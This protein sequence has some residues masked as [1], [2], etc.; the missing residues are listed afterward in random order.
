MSNEQS[1]LVAWRTVIVAASA[2]WKP[3]DIR[4]PWEWCEDHVEVDRTS[5]MPGKWKSFNSTWVKELMEV[6][7]DKSVNFI[8]VR[9]SAQSSKTQTIL[10]L[11]FWDISEDP[12]PEMYV[13]AN[14]DDAQDFVRDRFSPM[15]HD[16]KPAREQL[17]RETK[18]KFTFRT[19][20][21]YFVGAGSKAKLQG[22]PIKRLKL[23]EVRNYPPGAYDT[24][25]KRVRAFGELAQVLVI[26]TP[27][28]IDDPVD[29]AFKEGDQR[30]FHFPCP[31]CG[32]LQ[33]LR[34]EQLQF[35]ENETTKPDGHWNFDR[36]S[37]TIRYECEKCK[38]G[39]RDTHI[40][41]K[42]ICRNGKFIRMNPNAPKNHVSFTWN[43]LLPW[44][45]KWRSIIE[46]KIAAEAAAKAGDLEPLRTFYNETLGLPWEDR[47]GEIEDFG[48]LEARKDEY[49]FG[50]AWP[51]A[52]ARFMAADRQEKGGEHYWYVIR[53][54]GMCGKSRLVSYGRCSTTAELEE[55]RKANNVPVL[56]AMIDSGYK[57][58]Q[59][60]RFCVAT[61]WKAFKGDDAKFFLTTDAHGKAIRRY[62][63]RTF[64]DPMFG[65]RQA[66]RVKPI[67][68]FTW[69][70]DSIKDA[71]A[72]LMM[73]MVGDWTIPKTVG[74]DYL[75]QVS[76]ERREEHRDG[77][78]RLSYVWKRRGDNHMF[79]CELMIH[80]AA[81]ITGI[82]RA[83]PAVQKST[84]TI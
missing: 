63:R 3:Q 53:E 29:R 28:D 37:E 17:L 60:Y 54:F 13:L 46:E 50:D 57:A 74:R 76:A 42:A 32:H 34:V 72:E 1:T 52:R 27:G 11:C 15:L 48:F 78:G 67:P 9:C 68:L 21:M 25:L 56:N 58:S 84:K 35:D 44:W 31:K 16:C 14:S 12:G 77:R 6:Y 66:R 5:P 41:R 22:K 55:I 7:A 49:E 75:R 65:T 82:G 10:N 20:P 33:Q 2:A 79:D 71:L 23:D 81:L 70:N 38:H 45:V 73:G 69:S 39:I 30:T 64:V 8:A 26:S 36:L 24:V 43:A 47:L 4:K 18:L 61:G 51:E 62:W 80:V 59:V 83:S 40:E 19:M